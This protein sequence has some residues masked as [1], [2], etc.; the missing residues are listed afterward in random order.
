MFL[1][2]NC[3]QTTRTDSILD[4]SALKC[5]KTMF[6]TH[7]DGTTNLINNDAIELDCVVDSVQEMWH[8][9]MSRMIDMR[10]KMEF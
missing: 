7:D 2:R 1:P 9:L 4:C 3:K 10:A 6:T 5:F 8:Y